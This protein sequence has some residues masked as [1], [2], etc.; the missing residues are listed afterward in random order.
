M[1]SKIVS[2]HTPIPTPSSLDV[3]FAL[4]PSASLKVVDKEGEGEQ[5]DRR[6]GERLAGSVKGRMSEA[7]TVLL[8]FKTDT[9]SF[10]LA[11]LLVSLLA[12]SSINPTVVAR[13]TW[14]VMR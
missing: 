9:V 10:V 3:I 14:F 5:E 1:K 8:C 7:T 12:L 11:A 2:G 4:P 13:P 6:T